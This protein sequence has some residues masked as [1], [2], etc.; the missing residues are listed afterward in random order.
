MNVLRARGRRQPSR[1]DWFGRPARAAAAAALLLLLVG[2]CDCGRGARRAALPERPAGVVAVMIDP[3]ASCSG[4]R[5]AFVGA[6]PASLVSIGKTWDYVLVHACVAP[7]VAPFEQKEGET[8]ERAIVRALRGALAPCPCPHAA[9]PPFLGSDPAGALGYVDGIMGRERYRNPRVRKVVIG[10][11]DLI[12]D[13][14][15]HRPAV[16]LVAPA[17]YRWQTTG[18]EVNLWG[19]PRAAKGDS[20]HFARIERAWRPQLKALRLHHPFE[21]VNLGEAGLPDQAAAPPF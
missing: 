18:V 19:V 1:G 4:G 13:S 12:Q 7:H 21:P 8:V 3:T 20:D 16:R 6:L 9:G 17:E 5:D 2:G 10:W 15:R 14:C 11:C